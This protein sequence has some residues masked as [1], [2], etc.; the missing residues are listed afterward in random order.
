MQ[1]ITPCLWF[2]GQLEEAM[3]FYTG[4]FPDGRIGETLPGSDGKL[5]FASF[6]L[7]GNEFMGLN[8]GPEFTFSNAVSFLI[9]CD[10]QAEIDRYWQ[11]LGEGG[12]YQQCGWLKDRFGLSWQVTPNVLLRYL[13]DPDRKKADRVMQA[14]MPMVKIDIAEIE[15]AYAG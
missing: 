11:V 1:K 6:Y 5:L 10:D 2:D 4:V 8:G 15:R 14:M 3:T 13:A 12:S 9:R 7:A